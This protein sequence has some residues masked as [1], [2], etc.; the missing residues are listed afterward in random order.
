MTEID[1]DNFIKN[2]KKD[3]IPNFELRYD[4]FVKD[5]LTLKKLKLPV[6]KHACKHYKLKVTGTKP[7]LIERLTVLFL[8]IKSAIKIQKTIRM[9]QIKTYLHKR[10]PAVNNRNICNNQNDFVTMEPI[11]EIPFEHFFSYEDNKGFTY[12][13]DIVSLINLIK[14]SRKVENPYNRSVFTE[15]IKNNIIKLYNCTCFVNESFKNENDPYIKKRIIRREFTRNANRNILSLSTVDNYNPPVMINIENISYE[16]NQ[17]FEL[18][19]ETRR[20]SINERVERL[21]VEIDSLGNYTQSSWFNTLSHLQYVRLYRCLYDIW[22]YRG[23]MTYTVRTNICPFYNPFDGI[24]PRQIYHDT[25]TT[26]QIKKACIIVIEN[27]VYSSTDI[28]YRRIGALHALSAL[29]LVSPNAR[30][31]MPWLYESI[32]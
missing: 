11:E 19:N 17:R 7:V 22:S 9:N 30:L 21:F 3:S 27:L 25:I 15:D 29:T 2:K 16:L 26:E 13:F 4:N 31:A 8:Q 14:S 18:L 24:F 6:L 10:G 1:S 12:G 5:N 23:Q 32:A 28:D 20:L